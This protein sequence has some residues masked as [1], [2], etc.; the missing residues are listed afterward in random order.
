VV[1]LM[2]NMPG[3][4]NGEMALMNDVIEGERDIRRTFDPVR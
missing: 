2:H 3:R 1:K 4:M